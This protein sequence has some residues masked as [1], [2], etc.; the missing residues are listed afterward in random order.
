MTEK[1]L[2]FVIKKILVA[3]NERLNCNLFF[4][5][6]SGREKPNKEF[7]SPEI[8]DLSQSVPEVYMYV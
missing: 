1:V 3:Q 8:F 5:S 4:F 2:R 7:I 6:F